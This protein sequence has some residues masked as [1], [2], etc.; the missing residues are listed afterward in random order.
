[1]L[2]FTS[3]SP[4]CPAPP[5]RCGAHR[6]AVRHGFDVGAGVVAELLLVGSQEAE[7]MPMVPGGGAVPGHRAVA[8]VREVL[9]GRDTEEP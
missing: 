2:P 3:P 9:A 7:G 8:V 6:A 5:L 4:S 1:M